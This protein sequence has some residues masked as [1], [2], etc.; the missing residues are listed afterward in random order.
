[1]IRVEVLTTNAFF[2][3]DRERGHRRIA[4]RHGRKGPGAAV[5]RHRLAGRGVAA[6]SPRVP[7]RSFVHFHSYPILSRTSQDKARELVR[8]LTRSQLR[9]RLYL[10]PF[11]GIQQRVVLAR[12]SAAACRRSTGG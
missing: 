3:F 2:S 9:S 12:A 6:H 7:R 4:G 5:G 10:V 11:G 1:M 8:R